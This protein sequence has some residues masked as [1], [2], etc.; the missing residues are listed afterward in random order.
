MTKKPIDHDE[1]GICIGTSY[2]KLDG[3]VRIEFGKPVAWLGLP[4]LQAIELA[5]HL[6]K[7]AGHLL[8]HAGA[9]KL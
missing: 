4:P 3:I 5:R 2:D 9:K 6:L 1:G 7:H 8:K